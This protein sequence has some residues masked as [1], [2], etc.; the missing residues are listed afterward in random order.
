[1]FY[2]LLSVKK[3][4]V[5]TQTGKSQKQH[6]LLL[7]DSILNSI[8]LNRKKIVWVWSERSDVPPVWQLWMKKTKQNIEQKA[9]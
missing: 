2:G 3:S 8:S 7:F 9:H 4:A 5:Q 6:E 1:M